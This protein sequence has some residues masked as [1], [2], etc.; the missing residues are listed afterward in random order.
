MLNIGHP[1]SFWALTF[2]YKAKLCHR[3]KILGCVAEMFYW[4]RT[5]MCFGLHL[6]IKSCQVCV[7]Y[8]LNAIYFLDVSY[9]HTSMQTTLDLVNMTFLFRHTEI[10][11]PSIS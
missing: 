1:T 8:F 7:L 10:S 6:V 9:P 5:Y 4:N 11:F 2:K 3:V